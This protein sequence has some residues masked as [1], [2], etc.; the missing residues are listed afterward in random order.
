MS[1]TR[2]EALQTLELPPDYTKESLENARKVFKSKYHPDKAGN[3][4][5]KRE[6]MAQKYALGQEAYDVLK[7]NLDSKP[8]SNYK[9]TTSTYSSS[10]NYSSDIWDAFEYKP[11]KETTT[12]TSTSSDSNTEAN[13]SGFGTY[14]SPTKTTTVTPPKIKTKMGLGKKIFIII[15]ALI[16]VPSIASCVFDGFQNMI[17]VNFD[18]EKGKAGID[19]NYTDIKPVSEVGINYLGEGKYSVGVALKNENPTF[20]L[21]SIRVKFTAYNE[22]GSV[23]GGGTTNVELP[24]APEDVFYAGTV[25]GDCD[26]AVHSVKATVENGSTEWYPGK[27]FVYNNPLVV[28]SATVDEDGNYEAVVTN[29]GDVYLGETIS[30]SIIYMKD[31][32]PIFACED[33]NSVKL[34]PGESCTVSGAGYNRDIITGYDDFIV[35]AYK[36]VK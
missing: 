20:T 13:K 1:M 33:S 30:E 9:T 22:L 29:A 7:S 24:I 32:L 28:D 5:L 6:L 19:F 8:T 25:F 17:G 10:T 2:T 23:V 16:F 3:D 15:L 12:K 11:D 4:E 36:R 21:K 27:K 14:N 31:G 34:E 18:S 26:G 35:K